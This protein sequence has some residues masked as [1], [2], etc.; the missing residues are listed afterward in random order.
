MIFF[1][2][3]IQQKDSQTH[4]STHVQIHYSKIQTIQTHT[5]VIEFLPQIRFS[6]CHVLTPS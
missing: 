2:L 6:Y 1:P 5:F 3:E 4:P